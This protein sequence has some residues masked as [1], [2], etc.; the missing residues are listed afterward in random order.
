VD[1][2]EFLDLVRLS[3]SGHE[4]RPS[5]ST[6]VARMGDN[7]DVARHEQMLAYRAA[8]ALT[9][10]I[11]RAHMPSPMEHILAYAHMPSTFRPSMLARY[12]SRDEFL[13]SSIINPVLHCS[14]MY[15]EQFQMVRR[16]RS[17]AAVT[18]VS[19]NRALT[20]LSSFILLSQ[21]PRSKTLRPTPL[22]SSTGVADPSHTSYFIELDAASGIPLPEVEHRSDIVA[23]RCR[24]CVLE[25]TKPISNLYMA[26]A[27]WDASEEDRWRFTLKFQENDWNSFVW[28]TTKKNCT[29]LFE[30]TC[31]VKKQGTNEK[32]KGESVFRWQ[33]LNVSWQLACEQ[34]SHSRS[35]ALFSSLSLP[36]S[37]S[38]Y[39][40]MSCGFATLDLDLSQPILRETR[41]ERGVMGGNMEQREMLKDEE[42][43]AR[44]SGWKAVTQ[45]F[46]GPVK[47]QL[48]FRISPAR[49]KDERLVNY[50]RYLP[51]DLILAWS[52]VEVVKL[53][54]EILASFILLPQF[55]PLQIGKSCQ[56]S[57][58][59][60]LKHIVD[61]PDALQVLAE[62]WSERRKTIKK[63]ALREHDAGAIAHIGASDD[64]ASDITSAYMLDRFRECI[65]KLYP[66][67]SMGPG[68]LPQ[69]IIGITDLKRLSLLRMLVH[70]DDTLRILTNDGMMRS[71]AVGSGGGSGVT[72]APMSL[73]RAGSVQNYR[74]N[75]SAAASAAAAPA[76]GARKIGGTDATSQAFRA[77]SSS[78]EVDPFAGTVEFKNV[79]APFHTNEIAFC[80]NSHSQPWG[81]G[82]TRVLW[83]GGCESCTHSLSLLLV[84]PSTGE[85]HHS[86]RRAQIQFA[87][88]LD[89]DN[90]YASAPPAA[91]SADQRVEQF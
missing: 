55:Q 28:K 71:G 67:L 56:L 51:C 43:L 34:I 14:G 49:V 64:A 18:C 5:T 30:L 11:I 72:R 48:T 3:A 63:I 22:V 74:E 38:S 35:F 76:A 81:E 70:S 41:L 83:Y 21:D 73:A 36:H 4:A 16:Q 65:M 91:P 47:S 39:V 89:R 32:M 53:F 90:S 87:I 60:F 80:P 88:E 17:S 13:P 59:L 29:L 20:H 27:E 82:E 6:V 52:S 25:G 7:P 8:R 19:A 42:I 1:F 61:V 85:D 75:A 62:T 58:Q 66:F 46:A 78:S 50:L 10:K 24:V 9:R 2:R 33:H 79:F 40:E 23:R 44:R 54:L 84:V 69:L 68:V 37:A 26:K 57:I 31:L 86:E 45:L 77:A 12:Q 15:Y